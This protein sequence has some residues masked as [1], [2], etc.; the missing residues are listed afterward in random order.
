MVTTK[1]Q[2]GLRISK[3]LYTKAAYIAQ[4]ECR[5]LNNLVEF[6][7]SQYVANFEKMHGTIKVKE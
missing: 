2:T 6:A 7:L 5:S 4:Q 1:I 3:N